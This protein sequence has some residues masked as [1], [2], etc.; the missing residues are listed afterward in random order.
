MWF[1]AQNRHIWLVP[2]RSTVGEAPLHRPRGPS[3]LTIVAAQWTGPCA[4]QGRETTE[5]D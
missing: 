4:A 1:L 5:A 3:S 2:L